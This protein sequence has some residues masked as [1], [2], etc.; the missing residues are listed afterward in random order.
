MKGGKR[1]KQKQRKRKK[2]HQNSG[3]SNRNITSPKIDLWTQ[4]NLIVY[5]RP[6]SRTRS[7]REHKKKRKCTSENSHGK[8]YSGKFPY[9]LFVGLVWK[10][11]MKVNLLDCSWCIVA[12]V[13]GHEE[14]STLTSYQR[15]IC[16][17]SVFGYIQPDTNDR[18]STLVHKF[19]LKVSYFGKKNRFCTCHE[20]YRLRKIQ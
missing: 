13:T 15:T 4:R 11:R 12:C 19:W 14:T 3:T 20:V 6:H 16:L 1:K 2:K 17:A 18:R 5:A 7:I 9:C 10:Y 8:I